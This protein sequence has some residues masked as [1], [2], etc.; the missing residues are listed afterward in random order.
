V[1]PLLG[2]DVLHAGVLDADLLPQKRDFVPEAL[3][4][5]PEAK[6]GVEAL[7]GPAEGGSQ[8][9]I[10]EG[11]GVHSRRADATR[12]A[13]GKRKGTGDAGHGQPPREWQE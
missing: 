11:D 3:K 1:G 7:S 2:F 9:E 4:L 13:S 12:P 10:G 5:G 8:G 6:A